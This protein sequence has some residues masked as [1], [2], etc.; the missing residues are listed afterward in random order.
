MTEEMKSID[1][2]QD[3]LIEEFSGFDD[4]G[5]RTFRHKQHFR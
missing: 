4:R 1:E 2:L 3:E 5:R